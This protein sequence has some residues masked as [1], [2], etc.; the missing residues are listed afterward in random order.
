MSFD[1]EAAYTMSLYNAYYPSHDDEWE[2][3]H[4]GMQWI[5]DDGEWCT[6][7][8]EHHIES[9]EHPAYNGKCLYCL[10]RDMTDA[11]MV[12]FAE[13]YGERAKVLCA[14][15]SNS[16]KP[17]D[18]KDVVVNW[19]WEILKTNDVGLLAENVRSALYWMNDEMREY[20]MEVS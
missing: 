16:G 15:L 5:M 1:A 10:V 14:M 3:P 9:T 11:Q 19:A 4:C 12:D 20:M 18:E 13:E 6:S 17:L 8:A 7:G 2:C